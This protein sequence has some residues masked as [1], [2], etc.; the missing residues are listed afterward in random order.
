MMAWQSVGPGLLTRMYNTNQF[1]DL[2]IFPSYTFLPIHLT[3]L[4]YR[5]HGKI[6]AYQ[7]WGSTKQSYDTMNELKLPTQF[8]HPPIENS[9]S[10]LISSYN[11]KTIYIKEC[12]ES[13][14]QQI[15]LFNIELVW[16]NDGSDSL[17]S[18]LLKSLLDNFI[19]TTRFTSLIYH[20]NEKNM[21]IGYSSNIGTTLCNHE[22]VFRMDSDDIMI[23]NRIQTQ[24]QFM[25]TNLDS[26]ICGGQVYC[27]KDNIQNITYTTNHSTMTSDKFKETPSHWFLNHP[28]VCYRKSALLKIGNYNATKKKM[29]EDFEMT[30]RM[31]KKYNTVYNLPEPLLFYRLHDEQIT[32][33][34]GTEGREYWHKIRMQL[35]EEIFFDYTLV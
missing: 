29:V 21:G 20:E 11:T 5:G 3:G 1:K 17:Q 24:I 14:K 9:I 15:G 22:L 26:M 28:T 6:Y 12:L 19:K 30:L 4:E 8:L 16:I 13:I 33:N 34:G 7:A 31:L 2:H 10:I 27:F 35:I 23:Y 25:N 32:N 18:K